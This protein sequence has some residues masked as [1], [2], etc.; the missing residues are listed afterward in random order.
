MLSFPAIGTSSAIRVRSDIPTRLAPAARGTSLAL[1]FRANTFLWQT[2]HI[3]SCSIRG[4]VESDSVVT[5]GYM[6][7]TLAWS[8]HYAKKRGSRE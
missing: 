6:G 1:G 2:R 7:T 4:E 8:S 3:R 5:A